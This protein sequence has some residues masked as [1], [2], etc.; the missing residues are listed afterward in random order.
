MAEIRIDIARHGDSSCCTRNSATSIERDAF[1]EFAREKSVILM[2]PPVIFEKMG[3]PRLL[4][5]YVGNVNDSLY[6]HISFISTIN[7]AIN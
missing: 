2:L 4:F 3:K 6:T 5:S 1:R 7:F